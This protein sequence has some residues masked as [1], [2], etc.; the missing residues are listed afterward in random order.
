VTEIAHYNVLERLG[1]SANGELFR[2]RD[3]KV[4]RTV[5]LKFFTAELFADPSNR[6]RFFDDARAAMALSHPNIATLFDVGEYEGDCYLAY[7]FASGITLRQECEGRSVHPRRVVELAVQIADALADAHGSGVLHGD[8]RP[9]TIIVTHKGSAKVL[10][11]GMSRWTTGGRIRAKAA[12][13]PHALGS[14]AV[15]IVSYMSPEQV[16]GGPVDA[17][18]DVFSLGVIAY[19]MLTGRNPFATARPADTAVNVIGATIP[20]TASLSTSLAD[21]DALVM[22]SMAKEIDKRPQS[23]ASFAAELRGIG[24]I[25][26]V[27]SGDA[28]PSELL[29]LDD[30]GGGSAKWW[31]AAAAIVAIAGVAWWILR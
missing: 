21:L 15:A 12:R 23:A 5:A 30:E 26:D 18:S 13:D 2:A 20:P 14:E 10:E 6:A 16:L 31:L 19:E 24:A 1:E 28:G 8:L 11:L 9:D 4:G 3:T 22:R 25:L 17:R 27:R 29:P 7:E